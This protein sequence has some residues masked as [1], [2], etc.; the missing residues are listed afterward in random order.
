MKVATG[1]GTDRGGARGDD[2]GRPT[3][4]VAAGGEYSIEPE[5]V[6]I[7][8]GGDLARGHKILDAWVLKLR[9]DHIKTLKGL[10][11]PAKS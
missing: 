5:Q 11:P 10:P 3:P 1:G 6:K 2:A 7:I 8:G 4:I 9:K